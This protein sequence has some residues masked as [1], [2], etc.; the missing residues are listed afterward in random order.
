MV[1]Q[2]SMAIIVAVSFTVFL[3]CSSPTSTAGVSDNPNFLT[4]TVTLADGQPASNA[5]IRLNRMIMRD[6]T[7]GNVEV[8][9]AVDTLY[10]S[11]AEAITDNKGNFAIFHDQ[12]GHY[13]IDVITEDSLYASFIVGVQYVSEKGIDLKTIILSATGNYQGVINLDNSISATEIDAELLGTPYRTQ[14]IERSQCRFQN[15]PV[16]EYILRISHYIENDNHRE[17][18]W[19]GPIAIIGDSTVVQEL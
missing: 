12:D 4:G 11:S 2:H 14:L 15:I 16:G 17:I 19:Q 1:F 8:Q 13:S 7:M 6:I 9:P 3:N 18:F 5:R 10:D